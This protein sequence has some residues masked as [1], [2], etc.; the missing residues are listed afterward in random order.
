MDGVSA[1]AS[2][3]AIVQAAGMLLQVGKAFHETFISKDY[4]HRAEDAAL[5]VAS[6]NEFIQKIELFQAVKV[7]A[8][9]P[10]TVTSTPTS[11]TATTIALTPISTP[12]TSVGSSAT[13]GLD[14]ILVECKEQLR[15][16]QGKVHK[17]VV[18]KGASKL[19]R[20]VGAVRMK[21]NEPEFAQI[22]STITVMLQQLTLFIS[23]AQ[24]QFSQESRIASQERHAELLY[25]HQGLEMR[26]QDISQQGTDQ[27]ATL[28]ADLQ[29]TMEDHHMKF[30]T[31]VSAFEQSKDLIM[32]SLEKLSISPRLDRSESGLS[33]TT[34]ATDSEPVDDEELIAPIAPGLIIVCPQYNFRENRLRE[35][36]VAGTLIDRVDDWLGPSC[37]HGSILSIQLAHDQD[38]V[39]DLC[40]R[41]V[42]ELV[43]SGESLLCYNGLPGDGPPPAPGWHTMAHAIWWLSGQLRI[44][45]PHQDGHMPSHGYVPN[46]E[47][48]VE[49][50]E[51]QVDTTTFVVLFLLTRSCP[52]QS[53]RKLY[54]LLVGRLIQL[55][56]ASKVRLLVFSDQPGDPALRTLPPNA[57]ATCSQDDE[58][59]ILDEWE[60]VILDG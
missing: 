36:K 19:K 25:K 12:G 47:A 42:Q 7:I 52:T 45:I 3:I 4:D 48:I 58:Q 22:E 41:I 30:D 8:S 31:Q 40:N 33:G 35:P 13:L 23:L 51:K 6:I 60:P 27:Q 5:R 50:L 53:D 38:N 10:P 15:R 55:S 20:F 16:L 44:P 1:A 2:A 54:E 29:R 49:R 18:P 57:T 59:V 11:S 32:S 39:H 21:M 24:I 34:A 46:I 37:R 14:G 56:K 28:L 17:M 43:I 9:P 26:I